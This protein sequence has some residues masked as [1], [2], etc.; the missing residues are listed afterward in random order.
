MDGLI[1]AV[2]LGMAVAIFQNH[3]NFLLQLG[4]VLLLIFGVR[5]IAKEVAHDLINKS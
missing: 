2:M 3:S 4:G 1:G 5:F